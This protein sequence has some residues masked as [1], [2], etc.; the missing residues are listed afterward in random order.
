MPCRRHNSRSV[1]RWS[2]QQYIV[3]RRSVYNKIPD[4]LRSR[5]RAI[6]EGRPQ[7]NVPPYFHLIAGETIQAAPIWPQLI[8]G[9]LQLFKSRPKHYICLTSLIDQHTVDSPSRCNKRDHNRVVV[10]RYNVPKVS[11][12]ECD[13]HVDLQ[14]PPLTSPT[15]RTSFVETRC[16]LHLRIHRLWCGSR[17]GWAPRAAVLH[18]PQVGNLLTDPLACPASNL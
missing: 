1:E 4:L 8:G 18:C 5:G 16:T 10:V 9:Q 6:C 3:G 11:F 2:S 15:L 7:L 13:V 17:H 14:K 12:G